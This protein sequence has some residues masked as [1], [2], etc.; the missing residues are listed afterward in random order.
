MKINLVLI[1]V[2]LQLSETIDINRHNDI[3][4]IG[5]QGGL[6]KKYLWN[7]IFKL[8]LKYSSSNSTFR[9]FG[10]G[11]SPPKEGQKMINEILQERIK[12]DKNYVNCVAKRQYFLSNVKYL[13]VKKEEDFE[14][15]RKE[16]DSSKGNGKATERILYLAIPPSVYVDTSYK[17]YNCCYHAI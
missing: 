16:L 2:M 17:L 4:L 9:F 5:A 8:Y 13:P 7:S 12:C 1:M 6:S 11:R 15:L 3:V 14:V 10:C